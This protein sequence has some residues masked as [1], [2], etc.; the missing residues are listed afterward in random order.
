MSFVFTR[1]DRDHSGDAMDSQVDAF[2]TWRDEQKDNQSD[3]L[4]DL[5]ESAPNLEVL[6]LGFDIQHNGYDG[7]RQLGWL[8]PCLISHPP[9]NLRELSL[10]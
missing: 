5:L 8:S 7:S 4:N 9:A 3:R 2:D 1:N 10:E 6:F